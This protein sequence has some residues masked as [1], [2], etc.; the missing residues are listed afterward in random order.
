MRAKYCVPFKALVPCHFFLPSL[1]V[2]RL[3]VFTVVD[4]SEGSKGP[5]S[6]F[7]TRGDVDQIQV[8]FHVNAK[9]LRIQKA[10]LKTWDA[11]SSACMGN[12]Q[13]QI[14]RQ[15]SSHNFNDVSLWP[16]DRD[17]VGFKKSYKPHK[18][19]VSCNH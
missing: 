18:P 11:S 19:G 12:T 6:R 14:S 3:V 15:T 8:L 2:H 16:K 13:L 17:V 9:C 10:V 1:L 5:K 7:L 4:F